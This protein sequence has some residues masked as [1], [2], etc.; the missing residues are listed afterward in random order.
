MK[1]TGDAFGFLDASGAFRWCSSEA[2]ARH[3]AAVLQL[4]AVRIEIDSRA[5]LRGRTWRRMR[6]L[7]TGVVIPE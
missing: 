3:L 4:C 7:K 2:E 6:D 1:P 5:F